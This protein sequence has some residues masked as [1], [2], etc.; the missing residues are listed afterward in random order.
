MWS[1][2]EIVIVDAKWKAVV[3]EVTDVD[4]V[5][6][7]VVIVVV[8]VSEHADVVVDVDVAL[9]AVSD[10]VV[11]GLCVCEHCVVLL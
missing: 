10:V 8:V 3:D 6:V 4:V 1:L 11:I 7:V 2:Y 9:H 5:V